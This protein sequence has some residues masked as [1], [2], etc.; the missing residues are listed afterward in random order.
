MTQRS[1]NWSETLCFTASLHV[2]AESCGTGAGRDRMESNRGKLLE[3]IT[4]ERRN[5]RGSEKLDSEPLD[6]VKGLLVVTSE[7]KEVIAS[8]QC[9]E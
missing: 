4:A 6:G 1:V 8:D 7:F 3:R 9:W 5:E 2:P